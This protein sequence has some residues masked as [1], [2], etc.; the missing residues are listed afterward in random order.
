MY[1]YCGCIFGECQLTSSPP[2][3]PP[4]PPPRAS[5]RLSPALD[6]EHSEQKLRDAA[7][8][9]DIGEVARLIESGVSVNSNSW[10][11]SNSTCTCILYSAY[12]H[13][14]LYTVI[15][16]LPLLVLLLTCEAEFISLYKGCQRDMDMNSWYIRT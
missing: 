1:M 16:N 8:R 7:E 6:G 2:P 12:C 4:P 9:G 13:E 14:I 10:V 15:E 5:L 3:P 11:S